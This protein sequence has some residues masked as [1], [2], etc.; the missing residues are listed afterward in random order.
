[1]L[2]A[3]LC[4]LP[5]LAVLLGLLRLDAHMVGFTPVDLAVLAAGGAP[6]G[7]VV[8]C[9]RRT[10]CA[11]FVIGILLA[12]GL[13]LLVVAVAHAAPPAC[14]GW[15]APNGSGS[16]CTESAPCNVGTWLSNKAA[17]GGV[18]CLKDGTYRGDSQMLVFSAKSGTAGNPITARAVNDGKV[19]IDGEFH[20]RPL[21]CAASYITVEGVDLKNGH[22]NVLVQRGSHCIARRVV[23]WATE[24]SDG[25][26]ENIADIGGT[27][28]LLEDVALWGYARKILAMGARGGNGPNTA[29]RV[30]AEHNGSRAGSAQGNPTEA[31]EIGYNQSGVTME[32]V[33]ARR[34]IL[35]SA[36]EPEAA[37]H[38]F[39][40][41]DSALL[42]SIAFATATDH[43]DTDNLLNITA[44]AGSHAG[45]GFVTSRML[46][47]D[48]VLYGEHA[49]SD[50][51]GYQID[52][53]LGSAGNVA[54]NIISVTPKGGD[55]CAGSGWECTNLFKGKTLPEAL[56]SRTMWD[57]AP[58]VCRRYKDRVLTQEPLWPWPMEE[59]IRAGREA[60]RMPV[61]SVTA[62]VSRTLGTIPA[63]CGGSGEPGPGPGPGPAVPVPPSAVTAILQGTSVLVSWVDTV[64]TAQTGYVVERKVPPG[65]Y[66]HLANAPGAATRSYTDTAPVVGSSNCYVVYSRGVAGPS[67]FSPEAC[68][69]VGAPP[70]PGGSVPLSCEGSLEA[71]GKISMQCHPT[72]QAGR[73]R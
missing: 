35:T 66:D 7:Y 29:R 72:P 48:I 23:A 34:N 28:N 43:Y 36:T 68:V 21:D 45:S 32:N 42:G 62:A 40:T 18:L 11:I 9:L 19:L 31:A 73:R 67:G 55:V 14:T 2:G 15:A 63:Q 25:G 60:S 20:R 5:V 56:G 16:A 38:A 54:K 50:L 46:V 64:N 1:M 53:G 3:V 37:I 41:H 24:S 57:V 26:I 59:R 49:R 58:G 47:Q 27:H 30:W 17:P 33:I 12:V 69:Q 51:K 44:E 39:S 61:T 4:G 71:G 22:D 65:G 6:V 52:G 70:G 10:V 8:S 13:L